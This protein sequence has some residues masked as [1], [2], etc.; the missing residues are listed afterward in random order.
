MWGSDESFGPDRYHPPQDT[1]SAISMEVDFQ[2]SVA[3]SI[4]AKFFALPGTPHVLENPRTSSPSTQKTTDKI[5]RAE[6]RRLLHIVSERNKRH[7]QRFLYN[8]LYKVIFGP[9]QEGQ[10]TITRR[11]LLA[12]AAE[13]L[14]RLING[15]R[16]LKEQLLNLTYPFIVNDTEP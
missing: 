10:S 7:N 9:E 16:S 6:Q 13:W 11:E 14:E 5:T 3:K 12:R 1:I 15:N 4:Y 2:I 8:E